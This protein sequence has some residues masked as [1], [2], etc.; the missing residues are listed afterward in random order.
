VQPLR[1]DFPKR[2]VELDLVDPDIDVV[3][4]SLVLAS[5]QD[6]H[7]DRIEDVV[8]TL[9]QEARVLARNIDRGGGVGDLSIDLVV[10][11]SGGRQL[12]AQKAGRRCLPER[13]VGEPFIQPTPVVGDPDAR[14]VEIGE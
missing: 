9:R 8:G 13:G 5:Q 3:E 10:E 7:I 4:Q 14:M 1:A 6:C 12:I 2:A 11:E